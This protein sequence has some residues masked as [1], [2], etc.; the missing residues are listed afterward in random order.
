LETQERKKERKTSQER[1]KE[2]KIF[3]STISMGKKGKTEDG[4]E[5][6]EGVKKNHEQMC[7]YFFR[8]LFD[9][10]PM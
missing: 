2:R 3:S 7:P 5:D 10:F 6:G 9:F 4:D 1:K 8:I